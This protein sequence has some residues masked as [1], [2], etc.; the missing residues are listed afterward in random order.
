MNLMC[1]RN[2]EIFWGISTTITL[3]QLELSRAL[4]V[5]EPGDVARRTVPNNLVICVC[6]RTREVSNS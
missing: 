5:D 1:C 2:C 3:L 6:S 4:R